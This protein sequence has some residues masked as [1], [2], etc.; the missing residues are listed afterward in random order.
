MNMKTKSAMEIGKQPSIA[1]EAMKRT[2]MDIAI[3]E[4]YCDRCGMKLNG[5][6]EKVG[7][8]K[9]CAHCAKV[10]NDPTSRKFRGSKPE[11]VV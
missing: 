9:L 5:R 7:D 4:D 10:A 6:F 11:G 2:G 3:E 8:E 1:K